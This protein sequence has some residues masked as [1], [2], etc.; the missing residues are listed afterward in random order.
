M[1]EYI[2]KHLQDIINA[3]YDIERIFEGYPMQFEVF[4]KDDLRRWAV[5]R[6]RDFQF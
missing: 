2:L 4:E 1:D 5:E 6:N 3:I